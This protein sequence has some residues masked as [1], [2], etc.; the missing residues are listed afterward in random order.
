LD[1]FAVGRSLSTM[2]HFQYWNRRCEASKSRTTALRQAG[3]GHAAL[4]RLHNQSYDVLFLDLRMPGLDSER[5]FE[6]LCQEFP[7]TAKRVVFI[8]GDTTSAE[9]Q[10]F[11][12]RTGRPFLAK[13]M[14]L[15]EVRGIAQ[16]ILEAA[17]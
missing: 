10:Q 16:E 2:Y 12:D 15:S 13:P 1:L 6:V 11:L 5:L 3:D 7:A 9:S 8:T 4:E 17:A 14:T